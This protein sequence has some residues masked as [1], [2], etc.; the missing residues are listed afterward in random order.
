MIEIAKDNAIHAG[1]DRYI[2]FSVR[3]FTS[4]PI[5]PEQYDKQRSLVSNPPYG[6]RFQVSESMKLYRRILSVY[7]E[8]KDVN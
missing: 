3:D 1:V 4:T 6:E 5:Q 7:E 8:N 2:H